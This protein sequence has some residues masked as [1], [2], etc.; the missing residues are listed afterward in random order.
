MP[1]P[2][3]HIA[4][5]PLDPVV[6]T[7][8]FQDTRQPG[9][10][11]PSHAEL[12][13]T[14]FRMNGVNYRNATIEAATYG[15]LP[16]WRNTTVATGSDLAVPNAIA[17][18]GDES[19]GLGPNRIQLG[20]TTISLDGIRAD[21]NGQNYNTTGPMDWGIVFGRGP[22][23]AGEGY[24]VDFGSCG[25]QWQ[26][27]DSH[28]QAL[29]GS[30]PAESPAVVQFQYNLFRDLGVAPATPQAEITES[31]PVDPENYF[32]PPPTPVATVTGQAVEGQVLTAVLAD[33]TPTGYQWQRGTL[34]IDGATSST[35]TLTAADVGSTIRVVIAYAGGSATSNPTAVVEA[36][37]SGI[38]SNLL[39]SLS[40]PAAYIEDS[41]VYWMGFHF[42]ARRTCYVTKIRY[43]NPDPHIARASRAC[44]WQKD[45]I[46]VVRPIGYAPVY[47]DD[48]SGQGK[49]AGWGEAEFAAPVLIEQ[50]Q[51]YEVALCTFNVISDSIHY[52]A[53]SGFFAIENS[54]PNAAIFDGTVDDQYEDPQGYF[55]LDAA[56]LPNMRF[57]T[58][59][60]GGIPYAFE[61]MDS[62]ANAIV[63]ESEFG[64]ASYWIDIE[65]VDAIT[66]VVGPQNIFGADF[67]RLPDIGL[68]PEEAGEVF[69]E[70]SDTGTYTL[71]NRIEIVKD[72]TI[73]AVRYW[74]APDD[75]TNI[76]VPKTAYVWRTDG[77]LLASKAYT[78]VTSGW[79]EV[80]L[81]VPLPVSRW[82]ELMVG[83]YPISG[84][85]YA[86]IRG[87]ETN[88][89]YYRNAVLVS[90]NGAAVID[91]GRAATFDA[92]GSAAFPTTNV[93]NANVYP[94]D[95]VIEVSG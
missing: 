5:T 9:G 32:P 93:P 12:T 55:A 74:L 29:A 64:A 94:I 45:L 73:T 86:A 42:I 52:C 59:R 92:S 65:A 61:N 10:A 95:I 24:L 66:P 76:N 40:G 18:E 62:S 22:Q 77:T 50:G 57:R 44:I 60:G 36:A 25:W 51:A 16:C 69:V 81:D 11:D 71:G 90:S 47:E 56:D 8:T 26:L 17:M 83:A 63:L 67:T 14:I 48:S 79:T 7:G 75:P 33:A 3:G 70:P 27:E 30:I 28:D 78:P 58:L 54:G 87:G 38:A 72:G 2:G 31:P 43:W 23:S 6:W 35:Y 19:V 82:D 4:G 15:S 53:T 21:D 39:G 37:A 13:G 88:L 20:Q 1:G 41:T 49:P 85:G 68:G 84:P 89:P 91:V 80:V 34:N 46:G